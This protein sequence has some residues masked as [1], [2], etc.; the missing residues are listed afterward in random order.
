MSSPKVLIPLTSLT[1]L[2]ACGDAAAPDEDAGTDAGTQTDAGLPPSDAGS[3]CNLGSLPIQYPGEGFGAATAEATQVLARFDALKK[4][5][6]DAEKDLTLTPTETELRALFEE[7]SPSLS[8]LTGAPYR[9][10][11]EGWLADFAAAAGKSWTPAEPPPAEGGRYGGEDPAPAA[12][13]IFTN[14]GL[15]LRQAWEKGSFAALTYHRAR[16]LAKSGPLTPATVDL[17]VAYFGAAPGADTPAF[18]RGTAQ[19]SAV[20]AKRRDNPDAPSGLLREAHAVAI[21]ARV[22][23]S[24]GGDCANEAEI[25]AEDFFDVWERSLLAT[26]V[27]YAAAAKRNLDKPSPTAKELAAALHAIG[28]NIGFVYGFIAIPPAERVIADAQ[29]QTLLDTH[30]AKPGEA[31]TTYQFA[32]DPVGNRDLLGLI[33]GQVGAIYGFS[34]SELASFENNY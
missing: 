12:H 17:L 34:S 20:Y 15:D 10:L 32:T 8:T 18:D 30:G 25:A 33:A 24:L 6:E 23:A 2:L 1:L 29:I 7:G 16:T 9:T 14:R 21:R 3:A 5:M 13:W 28:E 27:Y 4:A 26:V 19:Y 22:A 11:V 31:V